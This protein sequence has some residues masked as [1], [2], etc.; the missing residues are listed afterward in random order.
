MNREELE[1]AITALEA[2][3]AVLGDAVVETSLMALRR[4]LEELETAA[5]SEQRKLAT[6]LFMDTVGSTEITHALDPEENLEIMGEALRLLSEPI[7]KHGGRVLQTMGDGLLAVFGIPAT[8]ENDPDRAVHAALEMLAVARGYASALKERRQIADY[9]IRLG[10]STGLIAI[11]GGDGQEELSGATINLAARLEAAADPGTILISHD[12]YQQVRQIFDLQSLDPITAKGFPDPVPV[13]RVLRA[14]PRTFHSRRRGVEGVETRM[15][16]R[17]SELS[18][19]KG[20][21]H[22]VIGE[23]G[24]RLMT[25]V[26]EAGIGKSRLLYEFENWLD[27]QPEDGRSVF[28]ARAQAERQTMPYAF[29]RDLFAFHFNILD[30]D[31]A[32]LAREKIANGFNEELGAHQLRGDPAREVG[33]HSQMRA[34]FIGHLLGYDF[35]KSRHLAPVLNKP[36]RLRNEA[37]AYLQDYFQALCGSGPVL[38]LL[39]DLHWADDSSLDVIANLSLKLQG[40]PLLIVGTTRP[41]LFAS[42]TDWQDE[43]PNQQAR[44]FHRRLDLGPLSDL[45]SRGLVIDILGDTGGVAAEL[46]ELIVSNAEGNPFYVEELI[47]MLV[48]LGVI[49]KEGEGWRVHTERLENLQVPPTLS[50]VL[51]A[52][53]DSLEAEERAVLQQASV[54]GRIFWDAIVMYLNHKLDGE[55]GDEATGDALL[56]LQEKEIVFRR[57]RSIFTGANEY[58]FKHALF[59]QVT[60]EGMLIRIRRIYHSHV[61]DWLIEQSKQRSDEVVG[62]IAHHLEHAGRIEE[63]LRYLRQAARQAARLFALVEALRFYDQA[64]ELVTANAETF[65]GQELVRLRS[66]RGEVH[67]VAGAFEAAAADMRF[68]LQAAQRDEDLSTQRALLTSLGMVYRRGDNYE[69]ALQ[70]LSQAVEVARASGDQR[71][72]ADSLYHLGS[73]YW[74]QGENKRATPIHQ[75]ALHI[76]RSL[77]LTDLVAVQATHGRAEAHLTGGRPDLAKPLF[78]ESLRLSRQVGDRSYEAE[79]LQMVSTVSKG[80][81]GLADYQTARSAAEEALEICRAAH[82]DWHVVAVLDCLSAVSRGLGDYHRAFR[83]SR[84]AAQVAVDIGVPR[85]LSFVFY[86]HAMLYL[87]LGLLAQAETYLKRALEA[88]KKAGSAFFLPSIQAGLAVTRLRQ[89]DLTVSQALEEALSSALE[90]DQNQQA[91]GCLEGLAELAAARDHYENA[92]EYADRLLDLAERGGMRERMAQAHR[93]RGLALLVLGQD[94]EAG[95]EL[96]QAVELAQIIGCPRLLWDVHDACARYYTAL[97]N[98]RLAAHHEEEVEK[99]VAGIAAGLE[100]EALKA[101]LPRSPDPNQPRLNARR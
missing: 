38:L 33:F 60:Y 64:V 57:D 21:Y 92:I 19:L 30:D 12:T 34:H 25:I 48:Q 39:E 8:H 49:F 85:L 59:R 80:P 72:V 14:K 27:R 94:T 32:D 54:I 93:W 15:V 40:Q 74:S 61:A 29:L 67:A 86:Q 20:A 78:E 22:S 82:L 73:V 1:Q 90:R 70:L 24:P 18:A 89:G 62:L 11:S 101:G 83:R 99:I 65:S 79:N 6:V 51:Q 9:Q 37:L 45:E 96:K 7:E 31:T 36:Q 77:D 46:L 5:K 2:Q 42:R 52:R 87:D 26:G 53:L 4:Q 97:E 10:I 84:E 69:R 98:S 55:S 50:G 76:C 47:K 23:G 41:E 88:S 58:F 28:R 91:A 43:G 35:Q 13:Y 56:S 63:A 3:R 75:E 66:E 100:D 44:S 71:A 81:E 68:A 17:F 16:G 95:E